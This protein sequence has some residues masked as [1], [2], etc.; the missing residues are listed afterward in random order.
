MRWGELEPADVMFQGES[1]LWVV[2]H[3]DGDIVLL[4]SLAIDGRT[5]EVNLGELTKF[6]Y[7]SPQYAKLGELDLDEWSWLIMRAGRFVP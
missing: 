1:P 4:L 3:K 6:Q 5:N 2:V 7:D